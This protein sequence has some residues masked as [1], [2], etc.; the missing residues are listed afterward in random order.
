MENSTR[1]YRR[2]AGVL[3]AR[4]P[5]AR[6]GDI[7]DPRSRKGRRWKQLGVLL[8]AVVACICAGAKSLAQMEKMTAEMSSVM[9]RR[10]GI[11][12][13]IPDTTMRDLLCQMSPRALRGRIHSLIRA[14]HRRKALEP[15]RLPFGVLAMDG[16]STALTG[17]DDL[18]AQRQSQAEGERFTSVLR[19]ITCSLVSAAAKPCIDAVPIPASTNEM[20]HF[21]IALYEVVRAYG[22]LGMFRLVSYD[23]GACSRENAGVVRELDLHYLFGLNS[24]QPTLFAEAK[25]QLEHLPAGSA[26]AVSEDVVGA[27]VIVRRLYITEEMARFDGWEHLRTVLRIESETRTCDGA[28]V[29]SENR[30]K[31]S[32]MPRVA[33]ADAQWLRVARLHWGVENNCHNT[34]DTALCEDD[35]PWIEDCPQG[36]LAVLLLRRI[37][38]DLLALFRSV[39]LR[40]EE[41][42]HIPWADLLRGFAHLFIAATEALLDA[43]RPRT[44]SAALA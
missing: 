26:D 18:Y 14:A 29:A 36:A 22:S 41:R 35:K 44:P 31:M 25:R 15:D 11:G 9:R 32:S 33:L 21:A 12:R 28:V 13:R 4:L 16:K 17:C 43:T 34:F 23:A 6:L 27:N 42:R 3:A 30:Y 20:G 2:L 5:E 24:S 8:G 1:W 38:Y 7:A 19:T 40:S 39:T 10:L 37:A